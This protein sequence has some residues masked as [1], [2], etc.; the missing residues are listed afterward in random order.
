MYCKIKGRE[1]KT[2][3]PNEEYILF[4]DINIPTKN[5]IEKVLEDNIVIFEGLVEI[6]K[7]NK[8]ILDIN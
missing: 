4:S 5:Q 8:K 7:N 3:L 6:A 1:N 2:N